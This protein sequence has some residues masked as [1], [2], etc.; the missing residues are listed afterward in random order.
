MAYTEVVINGYNASPPPDDGSSGA[1][2]QVAWAGIKTKL[3]DPLKTAIESIDDNVA[4]AI[5]AVETRLDTIEGFN[6]TSTLYAPAG[7]IMLF[8]QT[9]APTGWTKDTTN[10]NN[11]ALR[12]TTG[13]PS[14]YTAGVGM[15]TMFQ[16]SAYT[17]SAT[18]LT[19][20]QIPSHDHGA[21]GLSTN[22]TGS[23]N[24]T[25]TRRA[26]STNRGQEAQNASNDANSTDTTS[27]DGAHSHS[28][29][30]TTA[31]TGSGGSHTHTTDL[32]LDYVDVIFATKD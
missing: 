11:F 7:T 16:S 12:V 29:S 6:V 17:T 9:S 21:S 14:A 19:T 26:S 30:G 15:S 22:S 2:N 1:S 32:R 5:G 24:H 3:A 13:T 23:H 18:T 10:Y 31:S 25:Y 4:T 20:S 27:T 28:I 8:R